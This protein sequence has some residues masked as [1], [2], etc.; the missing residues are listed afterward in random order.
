MPSARALAASCLLA[1][2]ALAAGLSRAQAPPPA[3]VF[4]QN[5]AVLA[6]ELS[7]SGRQ[8]ALST[9]AGGD[10][11]GLV[12]VDLG[13]T[14]RP[15]RVAQFSDADVVAFHWVGDTQLVFSL[16]D[17]SSGSGD[18]QLGAPGL[19]MVNADGGKPR[20]LVQHRIRRVIVDGGP[21]GR[22]PL[23]W[24]HQLLHVPQVA[25]ES[26]DEVIIGDFAY[27]SSN[28]LSSVNPLWLNV[29]SGRTRRMDLQAPA[30]AQGWWFDSRGQARAVLTRDGGRQALHW[31]AP[32]QDEWM[33]MAEGPLIGLPFAPRF[34]DDAGT[35]IVSHAQG[36]DGTTVLSRFDFATGR[37]EPVP[38]VSTPGFDFEGSVIARED[39]TGLAGVRTSTDAETTTWLDPAY[40][41][42]QAL[43]D[44]RLPG[45]VNRL[46]CRRCTAPDAVLLVQ[47][48]SDRDP[49][50]LWLYQAQ[51][52]Q[53]RRVAFMQ[54]GIVPAQMANVD[55]QR[56][57]ARD[58]R[59][60]PV[61]LTLPPARPPGQPAPAVVLVHGGPWV[62]GG[63]W[64]W[65]PMAQFLASRGYLVI[66]PEFRGSLGYG[67]AHFRAGWKQWGRA[68]QD[69]VADALL[70][71]Q[72][73]GLASQ[74]AC[75]AGASYGGYATLM[76]LV[77]HP[78][79]YRCGVAWVAVTD[80]FLFLEGSFWV[81]DDI[82]AAGRRHTLPDMVG[83][84]KADA[85]MLTAVSP[86]AQAARIRAPLLLAFGERDL[87]VPLA[88]GRRLRSALR[89][90]GREPEWV[91]YPNEGH[92]WRLAETRTDFAL[93][94]EAFLARHLKDGPA[95][96]TNP[97]T[98]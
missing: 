36:R 42:L 10:R 11:V 69:D 46:S 39:G 81:N 16:S 8:L 2:A 45:R 83:D 50:Q 71:A 56:I 86:V 52:K 96:A 75:I 41:A 1:A 89:D 19:Y 34:I 23:A 90:A 67:Q 93:R 63:H 21:L 55:F 17:L 76:G 31:R 30:G 59:D 49:G 33:K 78:E 77:R 24:H 72:K 38:W 9:A 27:T 7:P 37:P 47:S 15:R 64:Q 87:R 68:M 32:G 28:D 73:Q 92:S 22:E 18:N 25:S 79:L 58:G 44:D 95:A 5:P 43:A 98:R 66:S 51:D 91:T 85:E 26:Q 35:L 62:R 54:T 70:W 80:P 60:L 88:H 48:W 4:F 97:A 40:R 29:R 74:Q 84:A 65:D 53:W 61:W 12:V 20:Q 94:V 14:I 6:A 13:E 82:S 57:R 3:A